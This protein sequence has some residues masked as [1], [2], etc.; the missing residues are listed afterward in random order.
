M[1]SVIIPV[2]N[3]RD[4]VLRAVR[5]VLNQRLENREVIV[6][7]DASQDGSADAVRSAFGDAV[8]V[9][10]LDDNVGV[11]A[12]RNRGMLAARGE[13]L[14]FLDSDDEWLPNKLLRQEAALRDSGLLVCHT[15]EI[16]VRNGVRVNPH[17]HHQ[18]YGGDI[19]L[20][21][22]PLCVM[23][24]SSAGVHRSVFERIGGF[25]EELPACEDYEMWLRIA[26]R[27][28]V[29]YVEEKLIVKYG[30]HADQLSQAYY[31]MDRFRVYALDRLL[32]SSV[33]LAEEKRQAALQMLLRK[34]R[35]VHKGAEK[36]GNSALQTRMAEYLERWTPPSAT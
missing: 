32:M 25:D 5:S 35:I 19:F 26:A 18:K 36:R 13:W 7:D 29:C 8:R 15:N 22:L 11:S 27:W 1:F 23:S 31:A 16:W 6:V 4:L 30:G 34:A 17:K 21:A 24:P 33:E 12:A 28:S 3:R 2:Y 14:A 10:Q 9:L 20:K